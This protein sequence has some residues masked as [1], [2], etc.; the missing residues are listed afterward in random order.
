LLGILKEL[1]TTAIDY[2][3]CV[4]H[5]KLG[6]VG[7]SHGILKSPKEHR[8]LCRHSFGSSCNCWRRKIA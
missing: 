1:S 8:L 5:G 7:E 4:A 2:R 6:R 3:V